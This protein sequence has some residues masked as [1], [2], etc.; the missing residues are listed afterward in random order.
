MH[1]DRIP[2][3]FLTALS[4]KVVITLADSGGSGAIVLSGSGVV[5]LTKTQTERRRAVSKKKKENEIE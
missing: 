3:G 2:S 1:S 5:K 4:A